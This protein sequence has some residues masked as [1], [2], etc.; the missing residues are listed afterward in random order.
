MATTLASLIDTTRGKIKVDPNGRQFDDTFITQGLNQALL[1]LQAESRFALAQNQVTTTL[2]PTSQET[3][4]PSDF[5]AIGDPNA[6]KWGDKLLELVDYNIIQQFGDTTI[7]AAP[8]Y[9]YVRNDGTDW[10]LG[11]YPTDTSESI[12]VPYIQRL[13][14]IS[15]TSPLGTEYDE[16]LTS[17]AAYYCLRSIRNFA[18]VA[19]YWMSKY[20]EE[21]RKIQT[22]RL[23]YDRTALKFGGNRRTNINN[24][25]Q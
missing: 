19:E 4:L 24:L 21:L 23:T 2:T 9:A 13:D 25:W 18:E 17:Y 3:A 12:T 8:Q 6:I 5:M 22:I 1:T 10:L 20:N 14:D 15:T 7:E 11:M 16:P